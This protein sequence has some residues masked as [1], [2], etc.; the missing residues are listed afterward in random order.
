MIAKPGPIAL[1]AL[2]ALPSVGRAAAPDLPTPAEMAASREDV[3]GEAAIRAPGGPSYEFFR[4]LLPPL[5]YVNTAFRHYP[6]VLSAPLAPVKARWVSNGSGV[7][8]RADKPPMW[9]EAGVPVAFFVGD[10]PEP[11]GDD[12]TRLGGPLY[13]EPGLPVVQVGYVSDGVVFGQEA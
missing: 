12:V 5:R 13:A 9:K 2:F 7:N 10:K 1:L 11:F 8:L 4:D 6:I 3:W